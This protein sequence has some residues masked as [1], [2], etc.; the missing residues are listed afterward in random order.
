M[1]SDDAGLEAQSKSLRAVKQVK[2]DRSLD[3]HEI[4][5]LSTEPDANAERNKRRESGAG[6]TGDA[7][8]AAILDVLKA[9]VIDLEAKL[10]QMH[11]RTLP[12]PTPAYDEEIAPLNRAMIEPPQDILLTSRKAARPMLNR[13][14][15]VSFKNLYL[16]EGV[17]A[18]DVLMVPRSILS[19]S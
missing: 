3:V 2:L 12:E 7:D 6:Y 11:A 17:F 14:S 10:L 15:W 18:I 9:K 4:R 13:V 1:E 5:N 8:N 16:D 19:S